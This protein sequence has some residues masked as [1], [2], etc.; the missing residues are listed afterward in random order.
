[1]TALERVIYACTI[2]FTFPKVCATSSPVDVRFLMIIFR[3]YHHSFIRHYIALE[4]MYAPRSDAMSW[5][6][7]SQRATALLL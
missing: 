2:A 4:R 5:A 6:E 1:M 3:R 7:V